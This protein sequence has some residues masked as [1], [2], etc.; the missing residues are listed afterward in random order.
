MPLYD[1]ECE[2]CGI[3]Q[4]VW[5]DMDEKELEHSCG[6]KMKRLI[7]GKVGINMGV[8][9]YGYYDDTLQTYVH[10]NEQRRREMKKQ[11]VTEKIGKGWY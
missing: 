9:P 10:T 2:D 8:G 5:A 1:Y 11:G 4:D 7:S 3:V 6:K